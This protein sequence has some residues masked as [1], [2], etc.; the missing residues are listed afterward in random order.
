MKIF[1]SGTITT[2]SIADFAHILSI[3]IDRYCTDNMIALYNIYCTK[4]IC[5]AFVFL[6]KGTFLYIEGTKAPTHIQL[7][8]NT[9]E[10]QMMMLHR[11]NI[12]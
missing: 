3:I 12:K 2:L 10:Y 1:L 6:V 4:L 8:R 7:S 9:K 11:K 5:I